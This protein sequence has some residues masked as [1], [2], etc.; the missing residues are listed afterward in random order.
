VNILSRILNGIRVRIEI[1][2]D[3][4]ILAVYRIRFDL[5]FKK[6]PASGEYCNSKQ[7]RRIR[8][9]G[10][11]LNRRPFLA[12]IRCGATHGLIGD[13]GDRTFDIAL[14]FYATPGDTTT[15]DGCEYAY[16]GGINK[17][18]AARQF[19]DEGLLKKYRGFIFLDDD[20]AMTHSHLSQ[21]LEYCKAHD[22][23]LA[24]PSLT[25]DSFY[26][27][28]HL[29]NSSRSGSRKVAFVEVMC[30]YFSSEALRKAR[31][32]FDWS[33]STWGLDETWPRLLDLEPVVVDEFMIKHTRPLGG[34]DSP[35]YRYMRRIGISPQRERRWLRNL[36]NEEIRLKAETRRRL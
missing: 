16:T 36:S 22:L 3:N 31:N 30:P 5:F 12:I 34:P 13:R 28:K 17:Y 32:T 14:N 4:I 23:D 7:I 9:P 2:T 26:S 1:L 19:I 24:Q 21:F 6:Q 27:H 15:L 18:D 25:L 35:Y 11:N 8:E 20:L 29:L 10:E 33:Y